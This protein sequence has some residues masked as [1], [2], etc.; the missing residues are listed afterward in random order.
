MEM[1]RKPPVFAAGEIEIDA[2]LDTVWDLMATIDGWPGWNPEV[3]WSSLQGPLAPGS[4][5]RWKAGPGTIASTL[6][7]VERPH[8]L[9]WTGRTLGITAVHVWRLEPYEGKTLARTEESWRGLPASLFR[10]SMQKRLQRSID[11]GLSY[12]KAAAETGPR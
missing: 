3:K 12:L 10:A 1:D 2:G 5:F 9:A 8:L 7:R 6:K 4:R 11:A